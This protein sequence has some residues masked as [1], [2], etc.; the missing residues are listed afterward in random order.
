MSSRRYKYINVLQFQLQ[1]TTILELTIF[2]ISCMNQAGAQGLCKT[3]YVINEDEKAGR[4]RLTKTK[5]LNNC[6]ERI[7]K[8]IGMA[9]TQ[10][11]VECEAVSAVFSCITNPL[12]YL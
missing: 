7:I 10:K 2:I 5:D 9:Y 4:I 6:H 8:D 1:R 12:I 11:C 3:H